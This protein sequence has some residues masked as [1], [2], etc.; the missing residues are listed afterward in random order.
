MPSLEV[1]LGDI[2][3]VAADA[4][5][6]AADHRMRGGGG[7]DGAIHRAGGPAILAECIARF[8]N[9]LATGEAG[10]TTGG[11]LPA[12]WVIHTVGPNYR[13]G[14]TD[15]GLLTSCYRRALQVA[16]D[17]GARSVAFPLISAGVYG[18]P[19]GD[20]ILAAIE[21]LAGTPTTVEAV[22]LVAHDQATFEGIDAGLAR[23]TPRR[24]LQ[25][26]QVLHQ[27]GYHAARVHPGA[28]PTGM[29]WR[30]SITPAP[31]RTRHEGREDLH[32]EDQAITYTTGAHR[33][34]A[35]GT[36]DITTSP[37]S[38]A[39]LIL[40]RLPSLQPMRDD[41]AYA[42][43]YDGL[44]QLVE[45]RDALPIAYADYFDDE[46]GWEVGWGSGIRYPH[47]PPADR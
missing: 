20:A 18:W 3:T 33:E 47:P 1:I 45:E 19:K 37:E 25:G 22:T 36:V 21:T 24:I 23:W 15:R 14:Q 38:V 41:P 28:S 16:D 12:T 2:T 4:I 39:D 44:M 5:V 27:R 6:N 26:V 34:F 42:Q 35:G 40:A 13:A 46:P 7:V 30:V 17:L 32:D 10:W 31:D 29:H 11:A 8:P 43:W 9:G